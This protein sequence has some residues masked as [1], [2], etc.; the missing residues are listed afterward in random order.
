MTNNEKNSAKR[1]HAVELQNAVRTTLTVCAVKVE[2]F[3]LLRQHV[4]SCSSQ[5]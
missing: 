2:G 5:L 1:Y 3:T 4:T